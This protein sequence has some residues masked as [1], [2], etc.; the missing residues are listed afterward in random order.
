MDPEWLEDDGWTDMARFHGGERSCINYTVSLTPFHHSCSS[1]VLLYSLSRAPWTTAASRHQRSH[2]VEDRHHEVFG[3]VGVWK[4]AILAADCPDFFLLVM[5]IVV[6]K[7]LLRSPLS[8]FSSPS[9]RFRRRSHQRRFLVGL[10]W[11][12]DEVLGEVGDE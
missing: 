12:M 5:E 9:S 11:Q 1:L 6:R 2:V 3:G 7:F 8:S 4:Q 10:S